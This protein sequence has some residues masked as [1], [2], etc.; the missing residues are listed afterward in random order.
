MAFNFADVMSRR[1]G[2]FHPSKRPNPAERRLDLGG[3]LVAVLTLVGA[4]LRGRT[5]DGRKTDVRK[6]DGRTLRRSVVGFFLAALLSLACSGA[7]FAQAV[8]NTVTDTTTGT[9]YGQAGQ[10]VV[11]TGSNFANASGVFFG[12]TEASSWSYVCTGLPPT[13]TIDA[14][15]PS[16]SGSVSVYVVV[17][18][19]G[20]GS[21]LA[22][23]TYVALP[24]VQAVSPNNGGTAGGYQVTISGTN[25]SNPPGFATPTVNFGNNPA[26]NV[27]VNSNGTQITATAPAGAAATVDIT[28]TNLAGTSSTSANDQF[29]YIPLPTVTGVSPSSGL[30]AGGGTVT[31]TG[32]NLSNASKVYFGGNAASVITANT[33][34]QVTVVAP[35]G[36][37]GAVVDVTVTTPGGTSAPNSSDQYTYLAAPTVTGLSVTTGPASG[38]TTVQI[39]GSG[40]T[41]A[42]SVQ[43]GRTAGTGLTV[44]NDGT[45]SVT[46]PS[47]TSTVDV[48]VTAPGGTSAPNINDKFT[49]VLP[50]IV[51]AVAPNA[52]SPGGGTSVTITGSNFTN[53]SGGGAPTVNFGGTAATGVTVNSATSITATAPSGTGTV[54]VTVTTPGG[55]SATS[56]LDKFTYTTAP[57]V[58]SV[59]P[60]SGVPTGGAGVTITGN[61]FNGVTGV[62]FGTTAATSVSF[63]SP[64]SITAVAPAGTGTV[65]VKVTTPNGTSATSSSDQF[66]YTPGPSV[67]AVSPNSGVVTGGTTVNITGTNFTGATAVKFGSTAATSFTLNSA[68][69]IAAVAP[70]GSGTVDITVT[71]ASGTSGIGSADHFTYTGTP[72]TPAVMSISPTSGPTTGGTSVTITGTG[73]TGATAVTFGAA[74]ATT[75]TVNSA[76][77]ITA[78][79]PAGTLGNVDVTVTTAGGT[80]ATVAGDKFTYTAAT[81]LAP[82]VTSVSPNGGPANSGISVTITGTNFN[83]VTAVKFGSNAA[84]AY[85]VNSSTSITATSPNGTGVVDV[86]VTA[87]GG[88]SAVSAADK[89]TYSSTVPAAPTVTS[90]APSNGLPAGGTSVTITGSN[91]TGATAVKFGS[92]AATAFS[93]AS[94]TSITATAPAGSLGTVDITVT[95][96][97]GTSATSAADQFAY[98]NTPNAPLVSSISPNSGIPSGGTSVTITGANFTGA[99]TVKFGGTAAAS[100]SVNG[101]SSITAL[102]PPGSVGT[103]DVT[104][105]TS[106]GTSTTSAADHFTYAKSNVT[107]TLSATPNPAVVGQ[108]VTITARVTGNSPTGTVTFT[109][110]NAPLGTAAL[111]GGVGSITIASLSAGTHTINANY[112][113]DANNNADPTPLVITVNLPADSIRLRQMQVSTTP[114]IAN[115]AGQAITGAVD[116]AISAGF[117]GHPQMLTPNGSGFTYY[118]NVGSDEQAGAQTS[119]ASP[120]QQPLGLSPG[121]PSLESSPA[122]QS[123]MPSPLPPAANQQSRIDDDFKALG[124]ADGPAGPVRRPAPTAVEHDWLAWVDVRGANFNSDAAGNDLHGL[125]IDSILGLTRRVSPD[126]VVGVLGGYEHFNFTSQ[127]YNGVLK[128]DGY[129]AGAYLGWRLAPSLRFDATGAWSDVLASDTSGAASG[130]F[131]GSRWLAASTLTGTY[132]WQGVIFEPSA[133]VFA[134]WEQE[135]A[136]VDSLGTL[137]GSHDFE[138]GRASGGIKASYPVPFSAAILS[139]Y[140]G[141]YADY[142]FTADNATAAAAG[143]TSEPLLQGFGARATGG[144]TA[145]FAGGAQLG[146]GGEFSGIGGN[147]QIWTWRVR[148]SLPF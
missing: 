8:V 144:L 135:K 74:A 133:Q 79:S 147:T 6:T 76:T 44:I 99:T 129:T 12:A 19:Y 37:A 21:S 98:T 30:P 105:T 89:F 114:I 141:I 120:S 122:Q 134:L 85:T 123:Y 71:T 88:T 132:P 25:F 128:G 104:V 106:N 95:T 94:A 53:F 138:T 31:I 5:M 92:V 97:G 61:N 90:V 87:A 52:G 56:T 70:A 4:D 84:S 39:S 35:A 59:S 93:V 86:T 15:V 27:S 81:A 80:S 60:N 101:A 117:S 112:S 43:F 142:Y 145:T 143:L 54:D 47:G 16:G 139:P 7:A 127:A 64:T 121:Q 103:F 55:T 57:V 18:G 96:S 110:N 2:A 69:S 28:V 23:F 24:Q 140:V 102:S 49:Y 82:T 125:Q 130:N 13:C 33:A 26:T 124:Y 40:F 107:L 58:Y 36:S 62:T 83:S 51:T 20:S 63:V 119:D 42:T 148:G 115:L 17:P 78:T 108:P 3:F 118:L 113:G 91:F 41:G 67:T 14:T 146:A 50:P 109:T 22:S 100:F 65:D 10:E 126:L 75:Y 34:A 32:T 45:I 38:S 46:S 136:Y 111:S 68:T 72:A 131:T 137:Q 11:I 9:S 48:T 66:T 1:A 73:L 77:S 29:T 116:N